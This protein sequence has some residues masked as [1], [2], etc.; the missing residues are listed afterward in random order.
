MISISI[1]TLLQEDR[2]VISDF[3]ATWE[4]FPNI[5]NFCEPFRFVK[6]LSYEAADHNGTSIYQRIVWNIFGVKGYL[7]A[8]GR[9][10]IER[11][12][13]DVLVNFVGT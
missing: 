5:G 12:M 9:V 3:F 4:S 1:F 7:W 8:K 13:A 2:V 6:V 11:F 10:N